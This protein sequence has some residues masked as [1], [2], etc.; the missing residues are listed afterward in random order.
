MEKTNSRKDKILIVLAIYTIGLLL[1]LLL[2]FLRFLNWI[3]AGWGTEVQHWERF[4]KKQRKVLIVSNHPSLLEVILIPVLFFRDYIFHPFNFTPWSVPDKKNYFD[5]WY[6][7]W[8]KIRLVPIDRE[9]DRE[10]FKSLKRIKEI[11]NLGGVVILFPEGGRTYKGKN[12]FHSEKGRKIRKLKAGVG[13]LV[14]KTNPLIVPIWIEGAKKV[15]PNKT[16]RL[17]HCFPRL[18]RNVTVKI[19]KPI[20][21]EGMNKEEVTQE[22]ALA[23]LELAD[24][25]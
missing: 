7:T 10:A 3:Y 19:G 8:A 2:Y 4:P 5:R 14:L 21:I 24:E 13:W 15:L 11:L 17:Y 22:I 16:G 6:W 9:N 12:F 1:G 18:W 23:L 25:E 20:H